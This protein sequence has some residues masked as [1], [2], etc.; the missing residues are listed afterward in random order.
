[1]IAQVLLEASPDA[2][3]AVAEAAMRRR[4]WAIG[5]VVPVLTAAFSSRSLPGGLADIIQAVRS[6]GETLRER[7]ENPYWRA[8]VEGQRFAKGAFGDALVYM[9]RTAYHL[10]RGYSLATW[11]ELPVLLLQSLSWVMLRRRFSG[12]PRRLAGVLAGLD[13]GVLAA[14]AFGLSRLPERLLPALCLW[15]APLAAASYSRQIFRQW[16]RGSAASLPIAP[17]LFRWLASF[18]RV[19]TTAAFLGG[20]R[21]VLVPHA[22]GLVGCSV[23]LSQLIWYD[24]LGPVRRKT[25]A[26]LYLQLFSTSTASPEPP[27]SS[28]LGWLSLGGFGD[29]T[30]LGPR[31]WELRKAFD[32]I[33][34]DADGYISRDDL[35]RAMIAAAGDDERADEAG[36]L[37]SA[38]TRERQIADMITSAD[39]DDNGVIDF[40]EYA[41][42]FAQYAPLRFWR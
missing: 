26:Q 5:T 13:L 25:R 11:S 36:F 37:T 18:V 33:D 3:F 21:A 40:D 31:E 41:Q 27:D 1:M 10:R 19:A 38:A 30:H 8:T 39:K 14:V 4:L 9:S 35:A 22:I 42:I 7:I 29:E 34:T 17:V 2:T 24:G 23:L 20:D 28:W 15:T 32:A 6:K 16:T 12:Q